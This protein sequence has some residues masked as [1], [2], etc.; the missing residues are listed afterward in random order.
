ML[1]YNRYNL[2]AFTQREA[3]RRL[4]KARGSVFSTR[5]VVMP[6]S[7]T[8]LPGFSTMMISLANTLL[9]VTDRKHTDKMY[10][11]LTHALKRSRTVFVVLIHVESCRPCTGETQDPENTSWTGAPFEIFSCSPHGGRCI[12]SG[13]LNS[14]CLEGIRYIDTYKPQME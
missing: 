4:P 9:K 12:D 8:V 6:T 10:C 7:P 11:I 3:E 1:I 2:P 5:S 13:P 14:R